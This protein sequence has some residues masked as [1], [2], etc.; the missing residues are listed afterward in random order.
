MP[1]FQ[2]RVHVTLKKS[3]LD[4][5][6]KAV[7][8]ALT[9][10]GFS[11]AKNVRMGKFFELEIEADS[12]GAAEKRVSEMAHTLLSNPVIEDYSVALNGQFS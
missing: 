4:P 12:A 9:N 8:H 1:K 10:L 2:V 3:V 6:G 5:Q 7:E 11:E